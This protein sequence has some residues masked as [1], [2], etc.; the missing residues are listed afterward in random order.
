LKKALIAIV[1][2]VLLVLVALGGFG[3]WRLLMPPAAQEGAEAE[4]PAGPP[5][6]FR[7]QVVDD[8]T[9]EPLP[10][11]ETRLEPAQPEGWTQRQSEA[12]I[13]HLDEAITEW[14][15]LRVR[16]EG[17]LEQQMDL[18]YLRVPTDEI[19]QGMTFAL[20][21]GAELYG[22]VLDKREGTPVEGA[23][24][25]MVDGVWDRNQPF[26]GGILA[27]TVLETNVEGRFS[28]GPTPRPQV[29]FV[30]VW[31]RDYAP[32]YLYNE[33]EAL[34]DEAIVPMQPG[35]RLSVLL[36]NENKPVKGLQFSLERT[37]GPEAKVKFYTQHP[38]P[39]RPAVYPRMAPG[40]HL[41][42]IVLAGQEEEW[43]RAF[44]TVP[45]DTEGVT[46]QWDMAEFAGLFGTV[47]GGQRIQGA[48]IELLALDHDEAV[49]DEGTLGQGGRFEFGFL[50]PGGY[51]L[52]VVDP[53]GRHPSFRYEYDLPPGEWLTVRV[54]SPEIARPPS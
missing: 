10:A 3:S 28:F 1:T 31:H 41:L 49:L 42:R 12:G 13:F 18:F 45:E 51:A 29:R 20:K 34:A 39:G 26:A 9:Q 52:R 27:H 33:F 16:A 11:F 40:R 37:F 43:G 15:R 35:A 50:R 7:I 5:G 14:R 8:G 48:R 24:V 47:D 21:R 38:R 23:W 46:R 54:R 22:R 32:T 44:V 25:R 6:R 2:F 17:Y 53:K 19:M 30:V 36:T 4:Q